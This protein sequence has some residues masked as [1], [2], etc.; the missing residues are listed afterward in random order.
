MNTTRLYGGTGLGLAIA[1]QLV[2]TQGGTINVKSKIDEGSTFS[3]ILPFQKTNAEA[4]SVIRKTETEC[5]K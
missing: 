1:K 3:F 4:E 5:R 2:E